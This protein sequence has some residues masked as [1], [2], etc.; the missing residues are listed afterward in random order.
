MPL[1]VAP[2]KTISKFLWI[3]VYIRTA[4]CIQC[5]PK[6]QRELADCVR[7][8]DVQ[9]KPNWSCPWW[10]LSSLQ[11]SRIG[12]H[13]V[14]AVWRSYEAL[15][16]HFPHKSIDSYLDSRKRF[17]F[18]GRFSKKLENPVFLENLRCSI[19]DA[20]QEWPRSI[21]SSAEGGHISLPAA[22][23]YSWYASRLE[24]YARKECDS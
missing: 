6:S 14:T 20:L 7:K 19:I 2:R 23:N 11:Q 5:S 16:H 17:E 3:H 9:V 22:N 1:K 15:H 12:L 4:K 13:A 21:V 24:F 18:I 10:T 8:H